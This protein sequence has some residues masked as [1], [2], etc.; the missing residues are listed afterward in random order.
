ML[1]QI[2]IIWLTA[3]QRVDKRGKLLY[4]MGDKL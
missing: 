3:K 1:A 4:I 2:V